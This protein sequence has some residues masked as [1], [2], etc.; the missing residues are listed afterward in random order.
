[1][2]GF[3]LMA[4]SALAK[5]APRMAGCEGEVIGGSCTRARP[6]SATEWQIWHTTQV[7]QWALLLTS[8]AG[9][10]E[11]DSTASCP[12]HGTCAAT[13]AVIMPTAI[14]SPAHARRGSTAIMRI[15]NRRRMVM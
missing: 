4:S 5:R 12:A 13:F 6:V 7:S 10:D 3:R 15:R 8:E 1:M 2:G 14:V 11:A 9:W